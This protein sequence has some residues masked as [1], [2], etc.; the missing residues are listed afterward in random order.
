MNRILKISVLLLSILFFSCRTEPTPEPEPDEVDF[1]F[2]SLNLDFEIRNPQNIS[3]P[4]GWNTGG[5]GYS[6]YLDN[7]EKHSGQLSLK[8]EKQEIPVNT[9]GRCYNYLPVAAFAGKLVEFRGRIK[10]KGVQNGYAGLLMRVEGENGA[11]LAMDNMG[12]RGLVGDNDWTLVYIRMSI[13]KDAKAIL[14]SGVFSGT[15]TVWFDD[16]EFI[17][18]PKPVDPNNL[19]LDFEVRSFTNPSQPANWYTG[20]AGF[21]IFLDSNEKH[22]GQ[23]S[24][25]MDI[26]NNPNRTS[27]IF[28][29]N[30][31]VE[32]YA[33]KVV[34][35][36]G[37]IKTQ[38]VQNGY[39]GLS[40]LVYGDG[41]VVG[42][43]NMYYRGLIG[44][45]DW[46]Q[47]SIKMEI[48]K[49][50]K[51]GF[52]GGLFNG[53]GTVWFDDLELGVIEPKTSLSQEEMATLKQYVYPL[54]TYEP[55]GGDTKDLM[56][57]GNLIGNSKVVGLG[58]NSHGSSEIFNMKNRLIQYLAENHGF[59]IFSIESNMPRAYK[60]ND[61]TVRGEGNSKSLIRSM[62][63]GAW[64][65]DEVLDMV[66]W[67]RRF[68]EPDPRILFTGFDMQSYG[69]SIEELSEGF[70]GDVETEAI[71]A[72]LMEKLRDN[73]GINA[74]DPLLLWLQDKIETSSFEPTQRAWLLQNIV[75][76]RQYLAPH[77]GV[78][79]DKFMAENIMWIAEQNPDS[80]L[81]LWAHNC[82]ILEMDN[83]MGYHLAQK[84]GDD[85]TSFGFTFYEGSYL[86]SG[87]RGGGAYE[88]ITAYPGTLEYFLN[89]LNEPIFILDLKKLKSDN[90]K[91]TQWL[92]GP[93]LYREA[94]ELGD[95]KI[96]EFI[97]R[98]IVDDF[99]YLI[100]IKKSSPSKY[101]RIF[102]D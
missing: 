19:N 26:Q 1:D 79:R 55:D 3:L 100:Y 89:Q 5:E 43:D 28:N 102:Q 17:I 70:K 60:M 33:G 66:E 38:G 45:N 83:A 18:D 85:Y 59:D 51:T 80:K 63:M 98:T 90:H 69:G 58:E 21:T 95:R 61:Y 32:M 25:K 64:H 65:R 7:T 35:Y 52:F 81:V 68:N 11:V 14:F 75:I 57:L 6:I 53:T 67:M 92:M 37:W 12:N 87:S 41:G 76:L 74:I 54:R 27:G 47:V 78:W 77:R 93:I 62:L 88:G 16:F 15:G 29:A 4:A 24:L 84:F 73:A 91:D 40:L 99:D 82:H 22:S 42:S 23:L 86:A 96:P 13:S 50:A 44:D 97:C 34:E 8:M 72:D 31:P 20:G 101:A 10:T 48:S 56:I 94:D 30:F 36:T 46:T 9:F 49:G 2:S 39:A 71:I